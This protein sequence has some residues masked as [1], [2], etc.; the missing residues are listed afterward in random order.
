LKPGAFK[1]TGERDSTRSIHA[2]VPPHLAVRGVGVHP[3]GIVLGVEFFGAGSQAFVLAHVDVVEHGGELLRRGLAGVY[4]SLDAGLRV[5][6]D[7]PLFT[8]GTLQTKHQRYL[9]TARPPVWST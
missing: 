8:H 3:L 1:P 2:V 9:M 7:I 5:G 4:D 6:L